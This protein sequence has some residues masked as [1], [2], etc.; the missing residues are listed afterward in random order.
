LSSTLF[1]RFPFIRSY[2]L[3]LHKEMK[4]KRRDELKKELRR[5]K[6]KA[7]KPKESPDLSGAEPEVKAREIFPARNMPRSAAA[8]R[9]LAHQFHNDNRSQSHHSASH[10]LCRLR[11]T[12]LAP[13]HLFP[14]PC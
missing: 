14:S 7:D 1:H 11:L 2:A 5:R 12:L 13:I 10:N 8:T 3:P 4:L 6:D 9:V